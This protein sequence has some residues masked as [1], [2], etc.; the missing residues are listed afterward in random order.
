MRTPGVR[1]RNAEWFRELDDGREGRDR[2]T[3]ATVATVAL[4]GCEKKRTPVEQV[5]DAFV[6]HYLRADQQGALEF[7]A[8]GAAAQLKRELDDTK[9]A[10]REGA[11]D[12]NVTFKRVGGEMREK[13]YVLRYDVR[14]GGD[15]ALTRAMRLELTDLGTGPRVVLFELR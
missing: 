2:A 13:R 4:A 14:I 10:R 3:E 12:I 7:A 1:L 11:P 8:L 5:G 9:D 15:G 6:E